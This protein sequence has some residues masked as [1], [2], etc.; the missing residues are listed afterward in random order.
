M[1]LEHPSNILCILAHPDDEVYCCCFLHDCVANNDRVFVAYLMDED[2]EREKNTREQ[3]ARTA[4]RI[5]GIDPSHVHFLRMTKQ[6]AFDRLEDEIE[7][8]RNIVQT[9][10][11]DCVV[12][13][14][15]EGGHEAHDIA[16][17][18]ASEVVRLERIPKHVVFPVYHGKP[19]G[20]KGAR[21]MEGRGPIIENV[22]DR[23]QQQ[24]KRRVLECHASQKAHFDGLRQSA[25]DYESLLFSREVFIVQERPIDYAKKPSV[26]VGY[27]FHRNGFSFADFQKALKRYRND[28]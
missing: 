26:V 3:E 8:L 17:F 12:G 14:D 28:T 11:I 22:L 7:Q 16:S 2:V 15:Y 18:C 1:L 21:F 5:I 9:E 24:I 4:M 13:H 25:P 23:T 19:Q 6:A 20:R 10:K 27:E